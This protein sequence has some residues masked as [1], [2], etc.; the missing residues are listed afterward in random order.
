MPFPTHI[1]G[2]EVAA[3]AAPIPLSE[4]EKVKEINVKNAKK[5]VIEK[6]HVF[7]MQ[8]YP[9]PPYQYERYE[10]IDR[11][12][13]IYIKY[14]PAEDPS[15]KYHKDENGHW[16]DTHG[17]QPSD[18]ELKD[19]KKN[20]KKNLVIKKI[21]ALA[22]RKLTVIGGILTG[23]ETGFLDVNDAY[24]KHDYLTQKLL[25]LAE[26]IFPD[27]GEANIS[28]EEAMQKFYARVVDI[29]ANADVTD[30]PAHSIMSKLCNT[31][32]NP[33]VYF[34]G[35]YK[36]TN[37]ILVVET[38]GFGAD[39]NGH[40]ANKIQ[41]DIQPENNITIDLFNEY[42]KI[43]AENENDRPAWFNVL[44]PW[45][46]KLLRQK[47]EAIRTAPVS[48]LGQIELTDA[49]KT[50][51][52]QQT[53]LSH[54]SKSCSNARIPGIS[55]FRESLVYEYDPGNP[56]DKRLSSHS[57]K[58]GIPLCYEMPGQ[59][60]TRQDNAKFTMKKVLGCLQ[61]ASQKIE[62]SKEESWEGAFRADLLPAEKLR[63]II[64]VGALL[65]DVWFFS[66][67]D[68]SYVRQERD[69]FAAT[70][71]ELKDEDHEYIFNN[72][73]MNFIRSLTEHV[74]HEVTVGERQRYINSRWQE[75]D[76]LLAYAHHFTQTLK[77][78]V[79]LTPQQQRKKRL[80]DCAVEQLENMRNLSITGG[81][82]FCYF[83]RNYP[84]FK[85]A[86]DAI[87]V[88]AMGGVVLTHC[89]S[90]KDRTGEEEV[91]RLAM[92]EYFR[93]HNTLPSYTDPQLQRD[94]FISI[95]KTIF[96]NMKIEEVANGNTP[97]AFGIKDIP[98]LTSIICADIR[99]ALNEDK[100]FEL[101]CELA[102][103][104][105]VDPPSGSGI[106]YRI[107]DRFDYKKQKAETGFYLDERAG[108]GYVKHMGQI[109]VGSA[110]KMQKTAAMRAETVVHVVEH[111]SG[112]AMYSQPATF[113]TKETITKAP[114][115]TKAE[116]VSFDFYASMNFKNLPGL[117]IVLT[118]I[119]RVVA[120]IEKC[121]LNGIAAP[122]IIIK[123]K[124]DPK[125]AATM[126]ECS[127]L[128]GIPCE[129]ANNSAY[130]KYSPPVPVTPNLLAD[131]RKSHPWIPAVTA[132]REEGG[133]T[134]K[135]GVIKS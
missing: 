72:E 40:V 116:N 126:F 42:Q 134:S 6:M 48:A 130:S 16:V 135:P 93:L 8:K 103:L 24:N 33:E 19:N 82:P 14:D 13:V 124:T 84:A 2:V 12:P 9:E 88:E 65:S 119:E 106:E 26:E 58:S 89:K 107:K 32:K 96:K 91:Y 63:P 69:A 75:T 83:G 54:H 31:K 86:Y 38:T 79:D 97:G 109:T 17:N 112:S 78:D 62:E 64:Y 77:D 121:R 129:Y 102:G 27:D 123:D 74:A 85:S 87:L 71:D 18:A 41:V 118:A 92:L 30:M 52:Q 55:N 34:S 117:K 131:L 113:V 76:R 66:N 108:K 101:S 15:L 21:N 28:P 51:W 132:P 73:P 39:L 99:E 104:N 50:A 5:Y 36:P 80:I 111:K 67:P 81:Y 3:D 115:E 128:L 105:K 133:L 98:G 114:G 44:P 94:E 56:D 125:L 53:E 22:V 68:L 100:S 11:K 127:K 47:L 95:Y 60:T 35:E 1:P 70:V 110:I 7:D 45:E 23:L 122:V 29:I 25:Q 120:F 37:E 59:G 46:Q 61:K 20:I 43:F 4:P 90:G 10:T 49:Q 57:Y